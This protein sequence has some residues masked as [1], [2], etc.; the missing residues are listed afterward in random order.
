MTND[1]SPTRLET[2]AETFGSQ[3]ERPRKELLP[4]NR[5]VITDLYIG[6][7]IENKPNDYAFKV[8]VRLNGR[9]QTIR[10]VSFQHSV[11]EG[12]YF[13][14][15]S[16][17]SC[18][19]TGCRFVGCN[20]HQSAFSGC[21]FKYA[22]FERCQI[23]DDILQRE[24]PNEENLKMRFARSLRMNFQ[25]IGDAKAV[26]SAISLELEATE[27][28]L[29]KSWS[30]KETYYQK[31]YPG[32]KK[33]P[34]FFKWVEFKILDFIWGNGESTLKLMRTI[35]VAHILIALYDT[36]RFGNVWDLNNYL[37]SLAAS[38][39]VFF[40]I[41]S[42]HPYPIWLSSI[43][44]ATRLVGFAFLTAILVKRFGRR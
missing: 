24:A 32:W 11:F 21:N 38:P 36:G 15:C 29:K 26:N 6:D 4:G 25:Q 14:S 27:R 34:Q 13:N 7:A 18:D 5:E 31:K 22:V 9:K 19:F 8:Y 2:S 1:N 10:K 42:P 43:I 28:Y 39:G 35:F 40:G 37:A 23:D 16:F 20:F 12:C 33:L 30:S 44:A 17:D 41:T 3:G